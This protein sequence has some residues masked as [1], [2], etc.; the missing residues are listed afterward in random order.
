[1]D[2][3]KI[4]TR[5]QLARELG[6]KYDDPNF[7]FNVDQVTA[8]WNATDAQKL[9]NKFFPKFIGAKGS[10][11]LHQPVLLRKSKIREED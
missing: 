11:R 5:E 6:L 3:D 4:K 9:R 8:N 1:M 2:I 10:L 7:E